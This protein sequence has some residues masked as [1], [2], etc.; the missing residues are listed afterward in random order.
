MYNV[1][2]AANALTIIRAHYEI[3][4]STVAPYVS[5]Y[6]SIYLF[7]FLTPSHSDWI[8][9]KAIQLI[10]W[11]ILYAE[12]RVYASYKSIFYVYLCPLSPHTNTK[13]YTY[14]LYIY[15]YTYMACATRKVSSIIARAAFQFI[16][17]YTRTCVVCVCVCSTLRTTQ[18]S[19]YIHTRYECAHFNE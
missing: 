4:T 15:C 17:K 1:T 5:P 10:L 3:Y 12:L 18:H 8:V 19:I 11:H 14:I 7:L 16:L 9:L 2:Q 6:L 13:F